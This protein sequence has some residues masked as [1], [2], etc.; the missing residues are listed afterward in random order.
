MQPANINMDLGRRVVVDTDSMSWIP[1]PL[2][3]V[4]RRPLERENTESGRTTSIVRYRPGASFR[5]HGHPHGEEF[6]V[7]H[8][9]FADA[10]GMYPAGSYVRNPPG[11]RHAPRSPA[12]CVIFV[13]L[14]QMGAEER[15][16]TYVDTAQQ[17]WQ[18]LPQP[19]TAHKALFHDLRETVALEKLAEGA[20]L[21]A[22]PEQGGE[23]ILVLEGVLEVESQQYG[24][25]TWVR[26][27]P[28]DAA[29]FRTKTG[30]TYWVKRGHLRAGPEVME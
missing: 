20:L 30:C 15:K 19:G 25:G 26:F 14:C 4:E 27:P 29:D 17:D 5:E 9:V 1:S 13:K 8:G 23:E 2:P 6:L 3:G 24:P 10:A 11:S 12:G 18:P 22:Q 16:N 28:G 7:L 21:S